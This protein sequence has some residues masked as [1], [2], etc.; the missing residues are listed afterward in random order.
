MTSSDRHVAISLLLLFCGLYLLTLRGTHE[1][2]D[3]I[4]RYNLTI[5]L[6][7][8][9]SFEIPPSAMA[10]AT[11]VDGR[12]YSKYGIGMSLVMAPMWALGN[13]VEPVASAAL[14]R[15]MERPTIFLMSTT[16]QWLAALACVFLFLILLRAGFQQRTA[17]AVTLATG[18]GSMLWLSSQTSFENVL[19]L[20]LLEV[21]VLAL[22]GQGPLS[23]GGALAGGAAMGFIF[24]TRWADGWILFPGA[25]ALLVARFPRGPI[26]NRVLPAIAF[27]L[28]LVVGIGLT[29]AYNTARFFDPLELGYDDAN[30]SWRFLPRGLFGFLFSPAKSVFVFTPLLILA[31]ACWGRLWRRLGGGLRATGLFWMIAAPLGAYSSFETWDGGWCFGPRYLLPS[32]VLAMIALGEWIEDERWR[33]AARRYW[34]FVGLLLIG[35]YAQVVCLSSNFNNYADNYNPFRYYPEACPLWA[36]GANFFHP[37]ENLWFLKLLATQDAGA[38]RWMV[39]I[40]LAVLGIGIAG[41][42]REIALTCRDAASRVPHPTGWRKVLPPAVALVAV[43]VGINVVPTLWQEWTKVP[44]AGLRVV[45]FPNL[46]RAMPIMKEGIEPRLDYDWSGSRRPIQGDFSV[47]WWGR[48][49]APSS[50]TYVFALDACGTATLA[51]DNQIFLA[52]RGPESGRRKTIRSVS[53][54]EG[55]HNIR[56]EFASS[57]TVDYY[58]FNAD[59]YGWVRRLPTGLNIRWK[60]PG[61]WF[62]RTIPPKYLRPN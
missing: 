19:V 11:I 57:P 31:I 2:V 51:L 50:G 58:G 32:V 59:K 30:V 48:F 3:D 41:L 43:V 20:L 29:M 14:L 27:L 26:R 33:E 45:Y 6:L 39:I 12:V 61:G 16:N 28:P 10:A 60:P 4:P 5:A 36:C 53:L 22:I 18:L 54:N 1:S 34:T 46:R 37:L 56:I 21:V 49:R 24:L 44:G 9:H 38:S 25:L 13:A 8:Q 7:T 55:M 62:L 47:V 42:R 23:L 40:F 35:V 15:A 52:N 17:L